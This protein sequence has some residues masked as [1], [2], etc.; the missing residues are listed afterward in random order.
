MDVP[1]FSKEN[2]QSRLQGG[3][4]KGFLARKEFAVHG[5]GAS[6]EPLS[7]AEKGCFLHL[8]DG[9]GAPLKKGAPEPKGTPSFPD[10]M[11]FAA[12]RGVC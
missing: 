2:S 3:V 12:L 11:A 10:C 9:R 1:L 4:K 7:W 5:R 8:L 6:K